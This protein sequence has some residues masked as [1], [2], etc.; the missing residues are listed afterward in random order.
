MTSPRD[1][2]TAIRTPISRVRSETTLESTPVDADCGQKRGEQAEERKGSHRQALAPE[3]LSMDGI[4]R[5]HLDDREVGVEF[6][7]RQPGGLLFVTL[8]LE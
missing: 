5:P 6:G 3:R 4:H 7:D 1:A 8:T 2:P